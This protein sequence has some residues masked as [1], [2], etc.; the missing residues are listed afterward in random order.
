MSSENIEKRFFIILSNFSGI[1]DVNID[2]K[3][4]SFFEL[5]QPLSPSEQQPESSLKN[6]THLKKLNAKNIT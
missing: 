3:P 6:G 5:Q 4:E 1:P 2:C